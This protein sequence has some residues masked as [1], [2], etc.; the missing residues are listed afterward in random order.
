[1][2]TDLQS[3]VEAAWEARDTVST[4]TTGP[5]REAV[6]ETLRLLDAGQV[7]VAEKADGAWRTNQ[8]V[9]QAILLPSA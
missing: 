4:S 8:W 5:V 3:A 2:T 6:E 7:R 1:M 9:K